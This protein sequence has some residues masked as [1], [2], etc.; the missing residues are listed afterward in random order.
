MSGIPTVPSISGG[1][2]DAGFSTAP[3]GAHLAFG[4]TFDR[5][6]ARPIWVWVVPGE[7]KIWRIFDPLSPSEKLPVW[8]EWTEE[9]TRYKPK[10]KKIVEQP[11]P[12]PGRPER[13]RPPRREIH[14]IYYYLDGA[15]FKFDEPG[16]VFGVGDPGAFSDPS[17][18]FTIQSEVDNHLNSPAADGEPLPAGVERKIV[19]FAHADMC[20]TFEYNHALS[21]RRARAVKQT[22]SHTA[23]SRVIN[24]AFCADFN[25]CEPSSPNAHELAAERASS[26][27]ATNPGS[28]PPGNEPNRRVEL[29]ILPDYQDASRS[30][31]R[32]VLEQL[33]DELNPTATAR[34]VTG[35]VRGEFPC[36]LARRICHA[37]TEPFDSPRDPASAATNILNRRHQNMDA[38]G[39]VLGTGESYRQ[40]RFYKLFKQRVVSPLSFEEVEPQP[41]EPPTPP[42]QPPPTERWV[43]DGYTEIKETIGEYHPPP[44]EHYGYYMDEMV[45]RGVNA[46]P[47]FAPQ[48]AVAPNRREN[49]LDFNLI[50]PGA[51]KVV[52]LDIGFWGDERELDMSRRAGFRRVPARYFGLVE[53]PHV[54]LCYFQ[55]PDNAGFVKGCS[56][57]FDEKLTPIAH[58]LQQAVKQAG[59]AILIMAKT[60]AEDGPNA[61]TLNV[62]FPDMHLPRK[63]DERDP[64]YATDECIF[65]AQM[66]KCMVLHQLKRDYRLPAEQTPW[67]S[68]EDRR[69]CRDFFEGDAQ[70]LKL[71]H[72]STGRRFSNPFE[73]EGSDFVSQATDA[74]KKT[75]QAIMQ[76]GFY[77]FEFTRD[78]FRRMVRRYSEEFPE[79][80][81]GRTKD[82]LFNW[83]YGFETDKNTPPPQRT[84]AAEE[85][86]AMI[87]ALV[88]EVADT[89]FGTSLSPDPGTPPAQESYD[90]VDPAPARDL[91]RFLETIQQRQ[92][93]RD[94]IH[95]FQ[96]GDLYELWANRRFL[97]EDF[98]LT[99]DPEGQL[100]GIAA[101]LMPSDS[102]SGFWGTL[103]QIAK[104]LGR[105]FV[106]LALGGINATEVDLWFRRECNK[107][108]PAD[109]LPDETS[110]NIDR[111]GDDWQLPEFSKPAGSPLGIAVDDG[112]LRTA[113]VN[114]TENRFQGLN[115]R[116][117][118]GKGYLVQETQRRI[119]QVLALEAPLRDNDEDRRLVGRFRRGDQAFWNR[120][121]V[122][123]FRDVR[124]TFVYG[125][126]DCFRGVPREDGVAEALPFYSEPGLWVEHAH[127]YEDSNVDGQPFGSFLTNLAFE[128][129][130]LAF[131][132]GLLDE[133]TMHREQS[134][135]QPG[136]MQWFLLTEFGLDTLPD[137]Q[138]PPEDVPPVSRF[139]ISVNSHTHVPDLV[140]AQIVFGQRESTPWEQ[141]INIGG[142][143]VKGL[144]LLKKFIEWW[145]RWDDRHGFEKWWEDIKGNTINWG[146]DFAGLG[147]CVDK[148]GEYLENSQLGRSL[149]ALGEEARRSGES[150]VDTI[151]QNIP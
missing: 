50:K 6:N 148:A 126:H 65:R 107:R 8:K 63:F 51:I 28:G 106:K 46:R 113:T 147:K 141:I 104:F 64:V 131:G 150:L 72:W 97:F 125:N 47:Q 121:V 85:A 40:C 38:G 144:L 1:F 9:V 140:N 98:A 86:K 2:L 24:L 129:Q 67:L 13:P 77:M 4:L 119:D 57:E 71:P 76:V 142:A 132:E 68:V 100:P 128:I 29:F 115:E 101:G 91:L 45:K 62:F 11:P 130:E 14:H 15:L 111:I 123:R 30:V 69:L 78:D 39:T 73:P 79:R 19:L 94:R 32:P 7:G 92:R 54:F 151:D 138:N 59:N 103:G 139:R 66:V 114:Y 117:E 143:L 127:R 83:F 41:P 135:F 58:R 53:G 22:L 95:V 48:V 134:T 96:T 34:G 81:Y 21:G 99:D 42:V 12:T 31:I 36:G 18:P 56:E 87:P 82:I 16:K 55:T 89:H 35:W 5:C 108:A 90:R 120:A 124:T 112:T 25:P 122:Q 110:W 70:R 84:G 61:N 52:K 20:N 33:H 109:P 118:R 17:R 116:G 60:V 43:P 102:A 146:V 80:G 133:Y 145:E 26:G 137:F 23:Q 3:P 49:L 93:A 74:V 44:G 75:F 105:N 88:S 37:L 27:V 136:I 149:K 10:W